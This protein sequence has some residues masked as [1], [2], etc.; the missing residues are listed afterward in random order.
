M[1]TKTP[2]KHHVKYKLT[3]ILLPILVMTLLFM[4]IG[5]APFGAK[6]LL[7]SDLS[8][9]YLQFFAEF[10]RQLLHMSFS[11]YS[12]LISIGD[13]LVPVYAYYLLSPLNLI[14]VFFDP[15]HLPIA[16]DLIIWLKIILCS[17]SMIWFLGHKYGQFDLMTIC[18]GM[19]Y[20]L[21]GFVSMYFYDLMWLDAL[22]LLPIMVAGLEKLVGQRKPWL[23]V[24][25][26]TA[27]ILTNYYM[28]YIICVFSLG[29]FVYLLIKAQPAGVALMHHIKDR[30]RQIGRFL[31]YSLL[32]G[33]LSAIV[34]VPTAISMMSTGKK[35]L[36]LR[37]FA[38][39]GAFGPSFTVNLGFGGNDFTGRLVHNPSMFTGSLFI[40]LGIAYFFSKRI[41]SRNKQAAAYLL[42]SIFLGMWLLPLNTAWHLFQRPAG[43]PFRM[44]F[45][46]SFALIMIAYEGYLKKIF[47]ET[48]LIL[49]STGA[50]TVAISIGYLWANLFS[51]KM[52]PFKFT[53]PQL[54]VNNFIYVLVLGFLV[55]TA[56]AIITLTDRQLSS[57][58]ILSGILIFEL[59]LN[60]FVA[61]RDAPL[62]NQHQ[63]EERYYQSE[64]AI[65]RVQRL[66][67]TQNK[68]YRLLVM[69]HPYRDIY[70]I[71]YSGYNDSLLF[72]N[73][74]I[75]SYS[76]TLN[77]HTQYVLANLGF[78][79]R[80]IR[81]IDMLGGSVVT[82]YLFGIKYNYIIGQHS[83]ELIIRPNTAQLGF[84]ANQ[85]IQTLRYQ[86]NQIFKNLNAL[87]QAESGTRQQYLYRP[88]V[89][90]YQQSLV[91][92][93]YHY[94]LQLR[95]TTSGPHYLYI[96]QVRLYHVAFWVNG[97][98]LSNT[99]SGL[100]T[101]MIPIGNL[102]KGQLTTV[103]LHATKRL[104]AMPQIA[105]GVD[106]KK[107]T[108]ATAQFKH[109]QFD[110]QDARNINR[111]GGHF[112]GT[113]TVSRRNRTL[114]MSFPYDRGWTL[115]VDGHPH[116]LIKVAD[117]LIGAKLTP[118]KHRLAFNYHIRGLAPGALISCLAVV[119]LIG[120][121][122]WQKK[123]S[124]FV[125]HLHYP[126]K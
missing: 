56:I 114:L 64:Q 7:I 78:S 117:G 4:I 5:I 61:T 118:G 35:D 96:P 27:I 34:L 123:R 52:V 40:I 77:S 13:S 47:E 103:R 125:K 68:F 98:K 66:K 81:R 9:Q 112:R 11:S 43:F 25:G 39:K 100:G 46:F 122:I 109:H 30:R 48:K 38:L 119:L 53:T 82:N 108:A 65:Q 120:S 105:A 6:N 32:S 21:C 90:R 104:K 71:P 62:V 29:Y 49:I 44:V 95:A 99:Y 26:L 33:M 89:T 50:L 20:G 80:N 75:S 51:K 110:L 15:A 83:Q 22:I 12:F 17:W 3:A 23:Y 111:H 87:V 86:P 121:G 63:F 76:S 37:N 85:Q 115:H 94:R 16:I 116:K 1:L 91:K 88:K 10:R 19:A 2:S 58:V 74:G 8:T 57:R 73:H 42:G 70:Q 106:L 14:V 72:E 92:G 41:S 93:V 84:M 31:W 18:G 59:M 102:Q 45:L 36:H 101:E 60:F 67:F 97:A 113:V 55:V 24:F 126:S 28:G 69:D 124:A 54:F 79:S 107:F